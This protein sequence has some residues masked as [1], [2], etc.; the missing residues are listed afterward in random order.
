MRTINFISAVVVLVVSMAFG[1]TAF[2]SSGGWTWPVRGPVITPYRNGDDP[3]AAGQHR[4]VDIG[5]PV[6]TRV[7]AASAGTVTFAGVAGSSGLVVAERTSDGRLDLSYLHLSAVS[8]R[9]GDA[10]AAG[11]VLGAVGTS[12][13]RSATEP[14]LHFGVR[15]AGSHTAYRDPL[16]FFPPPPAG[17]APDP[18][19]TPVPVAAP[20]E[21]DPAVAHA[22]APAAA[23]AGSPAGEPAPAPVPGLPPGPV[24][25]P[26]LGPAAAVPGLRWLDSGP[27]LAPSGRSAAA[28]NPARAVASSGP[29][30]AAGAGAPLRAARPGAASR[31]AHPGT[32]AALTAAHG[33]TAA[34]RG[35]PRVAAQ[36]GAP[37]HAEHRPGHGI[38]LGWLAACL[39][40]V[41]AATALGHPDATRRAAGRG[42]AKLTALLR[43]ITRGS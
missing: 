3:Y 30:R 27:R 8:V 20:A 38:D 6:G 40:L 41:A 23:P 25:L 1:G 15:D 2:A 4:G 29:A 24:H 16:D 14:H 26:A 22:A 9:R 32:S 39:G 11:S 35:A 12:G 21:R 31:A 37:R 13:S 33:P 34:G 19:P 36:E 17:D 18:S 28:P 10:L 7:V 5:A 43:P 42:G